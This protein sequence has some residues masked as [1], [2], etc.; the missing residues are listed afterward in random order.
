MSL[1]GVIIRI[2]KFDRN[3][4][5]FIETIK[6]LILLIII[7]PLGIIFVFILKKKLIGKFSNKNDEI[8]ENG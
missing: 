7:P 3:S 2:I 8:S 6:T 4:E 1:L 5:Y